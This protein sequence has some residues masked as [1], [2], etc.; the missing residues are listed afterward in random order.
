[1]HFFARRG[2]LIDLQQAFA[3]R[4]LNFDA[5]VL[6]L[7]RIKA[8][9]QQVGQRRRD[10]IRYLQ[11]HTEI[12]R[13]SVVQFQRRHAVLKFHQPVQRVAGQAEG[14]LGG[15][16]RRIDRHLRDK[17]RERA[18]VHHLHVI[19]KRSAVFVLDRDGQWHGVGLSPELAI[20]AGA[21]ILRDGSHPLGRGG[22]LERGRQIRKQC[23]NFG[24][25]EGE[26]RVSH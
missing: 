13:I 7:E 6:D 11:R 1:M 16:D 17:R 12:A 14:T 24:A 21:A 10:A 4:R 19:R 3:F 15:V 18:I 9:A 20:N 2:N 5:D 25:R 26:F 23:Q 22:N 8:R